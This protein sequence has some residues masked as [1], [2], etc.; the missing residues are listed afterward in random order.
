MKVFV[1]NM[2]ILGNKPPEDEDIDMLVCVPVAGGARPVY[3]SIR[4]ACHQCKSAVWV[5][6][7]GQN[8]LQTRKDLRPFCMDC[9]TKEMETTDE[10]IK[11]EIVPGGIEELKRHFLKIDEN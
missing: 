9:A 7:S 5:S 6:V 4:A 8:V 3:G 2:D 11:A 1:K 10:E